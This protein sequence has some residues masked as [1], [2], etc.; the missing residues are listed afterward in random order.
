ML[1][2]LIEDTVIDTDKPLVIKLQEPEYKIFKEYGVNAWKTVH[3]WSL[4]DMQ[5]TNDKAEIALCL[6]LLR[7]KYGGKCNEFDWYCKLLNMADYLANEPLFE[8]IVWQIIPKTKHMSKDEI[9]RMFRIGIT[10][11]NYISSDESE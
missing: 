2:G 11:A 4:M 1:K 3:E 9:K 7:K 5:N 6:K 8:C 10:E